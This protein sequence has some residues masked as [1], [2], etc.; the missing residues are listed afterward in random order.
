MPRI[1]I[2]GTGI[3]FSALLAWSFAIAQSQTVNPAPAAKTPA[4]APAQVAQSTMGITPSIAGTA[5]T[6]QVVE[7]GAF[8]FTNAAIG[9]G[10]VSVTGAA[11]LSGATS[12]TTATGTK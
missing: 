11:A 2:V 5:G 9:V 3:A 8:G 4:T 7:G 12:K 1:A 6:A 10:F